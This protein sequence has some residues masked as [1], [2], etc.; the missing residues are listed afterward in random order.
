VVE[1]PPQPV[2]PPE[3]IRGST[4]LIVGDDIGEAVHSL[5]RWEGQPPEPVSLCPC[6]FSS[7]PKTTVAWSDTATFNSLPNF[8]NVVAC[9]LTS[10]K[11]SPGHLEAVVGGPGQVPILP[12]CFISEFGGITQSDDDL[13]EAELNACADDL[14]EYAAELNAEVNGVTVLG[15]PTYECPSFPFPLP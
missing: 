3:P 11:I 12:Q 7:M 10:P 5:V 14:E 15:N 8:P 6:A 1:V 2:V 4:L 9:Q 13:S